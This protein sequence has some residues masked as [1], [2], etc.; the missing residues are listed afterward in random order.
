MTRAITEQFESYIK[1]NKKISKDVLSSVLQSD[2]PIKVS[3]TVAAHLNIKISDKSLLET[4]TTDVKLEKI[5]ELLESELDV[6]KVEKIRSRVKRQMEKT[7]REY[8]NEQ[9]KAIQ[10]ELGDSDDSTDDN[11][12]YLKKI[13]SLKLTDEARKS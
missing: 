9:L 8:S 7:Q 5:L 10:R 2:D 4:A 1:V 6:L 13:N 3:N 12:D 11:E